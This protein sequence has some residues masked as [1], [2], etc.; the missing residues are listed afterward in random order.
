M[1]SCVSRLADRLAAINPDRFNHI[2]NVTVSKSRRSSW[3][4]FRVSSGR[5]AQNGSYHRSIP[6]L[7]ELFGNGLINQFIIIE[8]HFARERVF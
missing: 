2:H 1:V 8:Q 7:S 6:A 3:R 4:I 5:R